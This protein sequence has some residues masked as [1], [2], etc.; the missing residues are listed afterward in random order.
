MLPSDRIVQTAL[1]ISD[2]FRLLNMIEQRRVIVVEDN[3]AWCRNLRYRKASLL[4]LLQI[5]FWSGDSDGHIYL[6]F[7]DIRNEIWYG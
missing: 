7:R 4:V 2:L 5:A 3:Y 6:V 1:R